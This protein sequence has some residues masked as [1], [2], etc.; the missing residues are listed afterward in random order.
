MQY[1]QDIVTQNTHYAG[2]V[3]NYLNSNHTNY[4]IFGTSLRPIF[5]RF[6]KFPPQI[7]KSFGAIYRWNYETFSACD[8]KY[9][10]SSNRRRKQ[11]PNPCITG[12]AILPQNGKNWPK[13]CG[14]EF[15][16]LLCDARATCMLR[17]IV[18]LDLSSLESVRKFVDEFHATGKKLH[19][20]VNNG[21]L[22][23]NFKDVKRQYT[24]DG[25]ELTIGT[26]HLGLLACI[27]YVQLY[28]E[29]HKVQCLPRC[30][31]RFVISA[32]D[33]M[34]SSAFVRLFDSR[35]TGKLRIKKCI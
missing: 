26:N 16:G 33:V 17:F 11:R 3:N 24:A 31:F 6:G 12:D 9:I 4:E 15:G 25:F 7:C 20:I 10:Q 30:L 2:G 23:M 22:A 8:V 19:V 1:R 27:L 5:L 18:Q 13:K 35:I 28:L 34:F 14:P 29:L 21:G 32:K